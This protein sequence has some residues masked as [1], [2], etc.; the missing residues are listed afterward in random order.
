MSRALP[1]LDR[2]RTFRDRN[3]IGN[4][5][6]EMFAFGVTA[7]SAFAVR[8]GEKTDQVRSVGIDPLIDGLVTDA[9][10]GMIETQSAGDGFR[11]PAQGEMNSDIPADERIAKTLMTRG[12]AAAIGAGLSR[13]RTIVAGVDGRTITAQ[14]A[15]NR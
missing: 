9:F 3:A 1:G 11:R 15:R 10:A 6:L 7:I 13:V 12:L 5:R 4:V 14:F 8:F 2:R